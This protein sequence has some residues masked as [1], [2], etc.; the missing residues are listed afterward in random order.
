M[1]TQM[2]RFQLEAPL[3]GDA[4]RRSRGAEPK[5][6]C[7]PLRPS[8][9]LTRQPGGR[10]PG[11]YLT[12]ETQMKLDIP[13]GTSFGR[14]TVV[15]EAEPC[16]VSRGQ[17]LRVMTCKCECGSTTRVFLCNL[18]SGATKSCG[19]LRSDTHTTH[20][21][22]A[23]SRTDMH[24]LWTAIKA[25]CYCANHS[26]YSRYGARGIAM[27]APWVND[28]AAFATHIRE[29]I[30]ERPAGLS[31]DRID[32]SAGYVPGNLRWA[33]RS[34]QGRNTRANHLLTFQ[35]QTKSAMEW[36]EA[37]GLR[38]TTLLGRLNRHGWSV[39]KAL[40]TPAHNTK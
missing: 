4:C 36:A 7:E 30:G 6:W 25:R 35:S 32:N 3:G 31:L 18:R 23:G 8:R 13:L 11:T 37:L 40:T 22:C 1:L 17:R 15:A 12:P 5:S 38:Y 16:V 24:A 20:G 21:E 10:P 9:K 2:K 39:E 14:L 34:Q 29:N 27:Y 28:Y 33:T 19:C 26:A